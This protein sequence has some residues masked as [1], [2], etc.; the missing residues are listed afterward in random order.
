MLEMQ[1][2]LIHVDDLNKKL[3]R[4]KGKSSYFILLR[5]RCLQLGYNENM[6]VCVF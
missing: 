5:L 4:R 3:E 1:L 6:C 2:R